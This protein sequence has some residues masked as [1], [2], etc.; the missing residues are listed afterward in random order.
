VDFRAISAKNGYRW[1]I[2]SISSESRI[3]GPIDILFL[4]RS[5]GKEGALDNITNLGY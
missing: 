5:S 4:L 2:Q 3:L 1:S